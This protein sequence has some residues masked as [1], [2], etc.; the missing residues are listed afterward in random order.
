MW[1]VG[2]EN[3]TTPPPGLPIYSPMSVGV[4]A[5]LVPV[6]MAP[7]LC[8]RDRFYS[9]LSPLQSTFRGVLRAEGI[10]LQP[11]GAES[12]SCC[13]IFWGTRAVEPSS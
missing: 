8:K 13:R 12:R 2:K 11:L 6:A 1:N 4:R 10:L 7:T 5:R 3:G 9:L